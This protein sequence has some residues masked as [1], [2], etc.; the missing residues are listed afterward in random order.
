MHSQPTTRQGD[1]QTNFPDFNQSCPSPAK[2]PCPLALHAVCSSTKRSAASRP[3]LPYCR[4]VHWAKNLEEHIADA[5]VAKL[6]LNL[7]ICGALCRVWWDSSAPLEGSVVEGG[8]GTHPAQACTRV[9]HGLAQSA[10]GLFTR[11]VHKD[12]VTPEVV[13]T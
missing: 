5:T 3:G 10:A 12:Q 11:V 9:Q 7:C 1:K 8:P 2:K 4:A 13:D 6:H